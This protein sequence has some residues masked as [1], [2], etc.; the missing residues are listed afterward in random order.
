MLSS[1]WQVFNCLPFVLIQQL[2]FCRK[3]LLFLML[4]SNQIF[5]Y[6]RGITRK[7]VTSLRG[8]NPRHCDCGNTAPF[9]IMLQW[10]Q[11]VG[12]TMSDLTDLR[13]QPM[14]PRFRDERVTARPTGRLK[15]NDCWRM[16][17][18][19]GENLL[20]CDLSFYCNAVYKPVRLKIK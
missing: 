20:F 7:C 14:T 11:A 6:S 8:P 15:T 19:K 5:N 4:K 3:L 18:L 2:C 1:L 10:W 16:I 9:G 12:T 17:I 13:F